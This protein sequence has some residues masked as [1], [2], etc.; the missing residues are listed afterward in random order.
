MAEEKYNKV[1]VRLAWNFHNWNGYGD[2][3][4]ANANAGKYGD[5]FVNT[6]KY[7][8]EW[9]NFSDF[10]GEYFYGNF[11]GPTGK[12]KIITKFD[13]E[14]KGLIVFFS[15]D[16]TKKYSEDTPNRYLI[17]F[18]DNAEYNSN[19]FLI[20]NLNI[21]VHNSQLEQAPTNYIFKAPK[22]TSTLFYEYSPIPGNDI[23][24][25]KKSPFA[26]IGDDKKGFTNAWLQNQ[27]ESALL[28]QKK[29]FNTVESEEEKQKIASVIQK[30]ENVLRKY[31]H[32]P[33]PPRV[34][35]PKQVILYGPPGT[36]KTYTAF[37]RAHEI[38]FNEKINEKNDNP[39]FLSIKKRLSESQ[40]KQLSF[41]TFH[42]SYS[43]EDFI[44][45]YR[46]IEDEDR[47]SQTI[48]Y[49]LHNGIFKEICNLAK[50]HPEH[51]YVLII[52]EIN[53]GNISKIFG[54]LITLLEDNK[55]IGED[56]EIIATLPYS[57]HKFGV[58]S[59][60]YI[61][62]T[63]NS[64]DKSIAL[65]DIALRRRFKFEKFSPIYDKIDNPDAKTLLESLN[66][67]ICAL[68]NSDFVIGHSYF[69]N[70]KIPVTD[71]NNEKLKEVFINQILPLIEEY[72]YNDWEALATIL[73]PES[74]KATKPVS[75]MYWN[76]S[77]REFKD[78]DDEELIGRT[79]EDPRKI[80]DNIKRLYFSK[81]NVEL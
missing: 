26:Y 80:F 31:F 57:R 17:G 67:K 39:T 20:N 52:D 78:N 81:K 6:D 46:P 13:A 35:N 9:W 64:T 49:E 18:Y 45:G 74:I 51:N 33:L 25:L 55:R 32:P 28:L 58:P 59:N 23:T 53:R 76:E 2:E 61:I 3:E 34:N 8:H 19:N 50:D 73:G 60:V 15:T 5:S 48:G 29:L 42:Q 10:S 56:E 40:T 43:Y 16:I 12:G 14:N 71:E 70:R 72:F 77:N 21:D 68:K 66:E 62:G 69:M 75:K 44:E 1:L 24:N 41:V 27:L 4:I 7:A 11:A 37:S 22:E 54:E 65:V 79:L 47:V 63:M 38:L 30:T 36:G